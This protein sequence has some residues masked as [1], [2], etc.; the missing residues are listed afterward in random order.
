MRAEEGGFRFFGFVS[1]SNRK[2]QPRKRDKAGG[3]PGGTDGKRKA[4]CDDTC[5]NCGRTDH[6]AKD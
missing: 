3:A 1:S 2:C 6:W 5:N 4:T